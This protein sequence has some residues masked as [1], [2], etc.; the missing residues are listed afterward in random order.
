MINQIKKDLESKFS[1]VTK[2]ASIDNVCGK[3]AS[4]LVCAS[5]ISDEF[6]LTVLAYVEQVV[7]DS[8]YKVLSYEPEKKEEEHKDN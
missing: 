8:Y 5:A 3:V 7:N 6:Y 4:L 1:N 2:K